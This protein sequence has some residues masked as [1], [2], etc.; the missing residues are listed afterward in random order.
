[1]IRRL[2]PGVQIAFFI[3]ILTGWSVTL[4]P[5][6]VQA[7]AAGCCTI[8]LT[9][10]HGGSLNACETN[11][12]ECMATS[13]LFMEVGF[14]GPIT[15]AE[16]AAGSSGEKCFFLP[17]IRKT[18]VQPLK[19]KLNVP[20]PGLEEFSQGEGITVGKDTVAKY[21]GG[22]YKFF[23]GIAGIVAVFMI[24]FGGV[25]WL[26]S[27]GSSERIGKAKEYILGAVFGLLLAVGSYTILY[28]IN[29]SLVTLRG[30]PLFDVP[31]IEGDVA[32]P[33]SSELPPD[34]YCPQSG[35]AEAIRAIAESLKSKV[36]YRM[37]AKGGPPPYIYDTKDCSD[38]PCKSYCPAG[39]VCFDCSGFV[40]H[41][42]RC[43]SLSY[44]DGG[45]YQIF[46]DAEVINRIESDSINGRALQVGD[47]IGW[48]VEPGV[49]V[50]HVLIYIGDGQVADAHGGSGRSPGKAV[51]IY[52]LSDYNKKSS[53]K[54]IRR[55]G[56]Y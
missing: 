51:G 22:L 23:I 3:V 50:G 47:L 49:D 40:N 2:F 38:G 53:L 11:R 6:A 19:I 20:I 17:P 32:G 31:I 52:T 41:V 26:F 5:T 25:I 30:L 46:S 55:V 4:I 28:T 14:C 36:T 37:G 35:G 56:T 48:R 13:Q 10:P 33:L 15:E 21:I 43:A 29:P 34:L 7:Q 44:I 39:T 45:T 9:K 24:V 27:G 8:S 54:Y 16:R 18:D 1:M 12:E 42:L